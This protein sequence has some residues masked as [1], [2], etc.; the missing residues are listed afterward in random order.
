MRIEKPVDPAT[1][2]EAVVTATTPFGYSALFN[3]RPEERRFS[4]AQMPSSTLLPAR[5]NVAG[6]GDSQPS[7]GWKGRCVRPANYRKFTVTTSHAFFNERSPAY[8]PASA[9]QAWERATSFLQSRL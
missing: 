1:L 6:S 2:G 8:N 5:P 7:I 4:A 9:D 3:R